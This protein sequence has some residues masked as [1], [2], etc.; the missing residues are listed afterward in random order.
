LSGLLGLFFAIDETDASND[1]WNQFKSL[2]PAPVLLASRPS[3][4]TIVRVAIRE[5]HH[6]GCAS[7]E[8]DNAEPLK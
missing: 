2:Q 6:P 3:L 4:K 7:H 8:N 1:L 5:P